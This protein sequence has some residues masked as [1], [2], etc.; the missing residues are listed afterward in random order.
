[1]SDELKN[2]D[3]FDDDISSHDYDGIKELNNKAPVWIVLIFLL[4]I[5][6]SGIY[7]IR[8]FGHP[9][10][11]MDQVSEYNKSVVAFEEENRAKQNNN[12]GNKQNL[13]EIIAE[14]S[15]LFTE[16]GCIACHGMNGEGNSIGPNLTDNYWLN[17][18]SEEDIIKVITEGRPEKGM[19]PYKAMMSG[20]QIK[21]LSVFISESL[22][23]SNPD[24]GKTPQGEECKKLETTN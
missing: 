24:N 16:K 23:G 13:D 19:T 7:A 14:G 20:R 22:I 12:A 18:C 8:Y 6:F 21:N 17:G 4:S 3:Q 15:K 11:N 9:N 5:G 10:N 2:N 1:M